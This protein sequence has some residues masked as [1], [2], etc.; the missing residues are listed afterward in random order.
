[1]LARG[2]QVVLLADTEADW[3]RLRCRGRCASWATAG[4]GSA[5]ASAASGS[6]TSRAPTA[7][8]SSGCGCCRS[9]SGTTRWCGSTTSGVYRLLAGIEDTDEV[10]RF[11]QRWIGTLLAYD[12]A[13]RQRPGPHAVALPG[14][15]RQLRGDR[16]RADRAPQHAQVP[17]AADPADHRARPVRPRDLLQPAAG[18]PGL[19]DAVRAAVLTVVLSRAGRSAPAKVSQPDVVPVTTTRG[20]VAAG[21]AAEP[22]RVIAVEIRGRGGPAPGLGGVGVPPAALV[23]GP[24]VRQPV[25]AHLPQQQPAGGLRGRVQAGR[26]RAGAGRACTSCATARSTTSGRRRASSWSRSSTSSRRCSAASPTTARP[27]TG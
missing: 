17:A 10:E 22:G 25:R 8:P 20:R 19:A 27:G 14:P 15:R 9:P 13:A 16:H 6:P 21:S 18:H 4:P 23:A 3:E 12:R 7:R 2:S 11:V 24:G 26:P 1:M 5:S